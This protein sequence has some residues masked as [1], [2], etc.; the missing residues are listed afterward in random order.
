MKYTFLT[1]LFIAFFSMGARAQSLAGVYKGFMEVD[2]PKNTINFEITLKEKKG[3]LYGYCYRLF[4]LGDTLY[5]N[6]LKVNGRVNNGMLIVEDEYSV[7]NNFEVETRGIKTAFFF[8][9]KDVKDTATVLP[10][11]WNTS[12]WRDYRPLTG[13][14]YVLRE[15]NY[16]NTELY[17]RLADKKLDAEMSFDVPPTVKPEVVAKNETKEKPKEKP[18]KESNKKEKTEESASVKKM[19]E[20]EKK[21]EVLTN[22]QTKETEMVR[23]EKKEK[24]EE[25]SKR[26]GNTPEQPIAKTKQDKKENNVAST[27]APSGAVSA[28]NVPKTESAPISKTTEPVKLTQATIS[29]SL[30]SFRPELSK[31]LKTKQIEGEMLKRNADVIQTLSVFEDSITISLYD[32]GEIDGD[33]VSVFLNNELLMTNVG[34]SAKAQKITIPVPQG[35][36]VQLSLFAETLGKTPPNTGLMVVYTGD[37]RYQVFFTSTLE[38]SASVL[39]RRLD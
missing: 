3:K 16:Q 12:A 4:V 37:Q 39:F 6:L 23:K 14:V 8:N 34:L 25:P 32:N 19:P 10:G 13:A 30:K 17:K 21:K 24:K 5:Y 31:Q 35:K 11:K 18:V 29:D 9:L 2:S 22:P 1:V 36:M 38:K 26:A 33:T 20:A 15:K 7:S 27:T 28:G